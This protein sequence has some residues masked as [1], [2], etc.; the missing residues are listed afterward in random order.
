MQANAFENKFYSIMESIGYGCFSAAMIT[1]NSLIGKK[2]KKDTS[3][4][5]AEQVAIINLT[6]A[7]CCLKT[8]RCG[9]AEKMYLSFIETFKTCDDC[10]FDVV[11][12]HS[13]RLNLCAK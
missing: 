8:N 4:L 1:I 5:S 6:K 9:E 12:N 11:R 3:K 13:F 2:G 7:F 10:Q